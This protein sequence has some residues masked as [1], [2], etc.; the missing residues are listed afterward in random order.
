MLTPLLLILLAQ[1]P[2]SIQLPAPLDRVL[3]D[4]ES[5]WR[6][7][8][9]PALAALFTED[10]W[11]LQSDSPF[12]HRREAIAKQYTGQGGPLYLRA[13]ASQSSG[14]LAYILGAYTYNAATNPD[15]GK[16]T[17]VLKRDKSGRWLIVSDMD[18]GLPRPPR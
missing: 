3:R 9:A 1:S 16:F 18:N 12:A 2:A 14:N 7:K 13:V 15:Q 8:D 4:Y 17:L 11:V 10:G 5:A 6:A